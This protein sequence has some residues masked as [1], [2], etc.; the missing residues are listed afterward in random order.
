MRTFDER[1]IAPQDMEKIDTP[2]GLSVEF[3]LLDAK[4]QNLSCPVVVG[5]DLYVGVK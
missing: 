5:T 1:A 2:Y 3:K 4:K